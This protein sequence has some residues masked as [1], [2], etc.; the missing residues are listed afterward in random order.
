[1]QDFGLYIVMT[2]PELDHE[3][4][5]EVCVQEEVPMLQLRE[6]HLADRKLLALARKLARITEDTNTC[7]TIDD[8]ADIA[9]LS[10]ACGVHIGP[11]DIHWTEARKLIGPM[12]LGVST[13]SLREVDALAREIE[14]NCEIP[15][16][17]YMS[18]GPIFETNAKEIPDEPVGLKKLGEATQKAPL[19]VVAIGGIFLSNLRDVIDA[20][21]KNVAM[22]RQFN[23][24]KDV[25]ELRGHIREIRAILKEN[26][27]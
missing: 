6:K 11:G 20:G 27:K 23:L 8:R 9:V 3:K 7:F 21:A 2:N 26:T 18:F 22:I 13:H 15:R 10:G 14:I 17:D 4:F 24:S 16:P 19:P 5:T 25:S 1:M 12:A